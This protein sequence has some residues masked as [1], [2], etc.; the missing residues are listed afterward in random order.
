[1]AIVLLGSD[2]SHAEDN[3]SLR[4]LARYTLSV[5]AKEGIARNASVAA[6]HASTDELM[7]VLT[8]AWEAV[9]HSPLPD[10]EW[11]RM[12]QLLGDDLLEDLVGTS[13]SSLHRYR[14]QERSTPDYIAERLHALTLITADLAGSYN[15]FGIRRWFKRP[16]TQL[17]GR[18]PI[19]VLKGEWNPEDTDFQQVKSLAAALTAPMSG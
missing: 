19:E 18:A 9:E 6:E 15:P 2:P 17:D 8:R 3:P 13:Q 10:R 7:L 14:A 12:S 4:D 16:R 5:F 11:P 1:L